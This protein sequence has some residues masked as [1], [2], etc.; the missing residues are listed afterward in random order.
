LFILPNYRARSPTIVRLPV[1]ETAPT[2]TVASFYTINLH[3]L[4][5]V[6]VLPHPGGPLINVKLSFP[7]FFIASFCGGLRSYCSAKIS[8]SKEGT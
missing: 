1:L 2:I 4:A 7:A 3:I 5:I 8:G 6:F